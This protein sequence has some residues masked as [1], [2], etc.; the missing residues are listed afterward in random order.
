MET[1]KVT[2]GPK[3]DTATKNLVVKFT[4]QCL[5]EMAKK[6]YE[7]NSR[8]IGDPSISYKQMLDDIKIH[9]K[10]SGQC[11][12]GGKGQI[13]IDVT[14]Y[15]RGA[16]QFYEYAAYKD[17]PV[18]G[19]FIGTPETCL[20][21]TVAHEVAHFIQYTY[22]PSTRILKNTYAKAHGEGFKHVYKQLRS[23]LV[24]H[25]TLS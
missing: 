16:T 18:I 25:R 10:K 22:G 3:V 2:K 23:A 9:V 8:S 15:L 5:R 20:L 11:S 7:I 4:K 13:T 12:N 21:A 17:D 19:E 6:K 14:E 24:N 1:L